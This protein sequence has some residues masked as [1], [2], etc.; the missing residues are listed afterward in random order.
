MIHVDPRVEQ[1]ALRFHMA[2]VAS[3]DQCSAAIAIGALEIRA[4]SERGRTISVWPRASAS[5]NA[6]SRAAL[7]AFTS[8]PCAIGNR[9][10]ST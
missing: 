10:T 7:C 1:H 5:R 4:S 9:A 3:R 6:L 2:I 8:A